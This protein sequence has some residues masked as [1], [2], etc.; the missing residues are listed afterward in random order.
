MR[1]CDEVRILLSAWTDGELADRDASAVAAHVA[2]C[3][4][5]RAHVDALRELDSRLAEASAANVTV[6]DRIAASVLTQF[7]VVDTVVDTVIDLHGKASDSSILEAAGQT[8]DGHTE[9][10]DDTP[11][12]PTRRPIGGP[13]RTTM[14]YL[15]AAA[16]GFFVAWLLFASRGE[17]AHERP[18]AGQPTVGVPPAAGNS[19]A[20]ANGESVT[21][22]PTLDLNLARLTVATGTVTLRQPG[23]SEWSATESNAPFQCS[24]G[25]EVRTGPGVRCELET[26]DRCTIRL[27]G[28]TKLTLRSPREVELHAGQIWCSSPDDVVLNVVARTAGATQRPGAATPLRFSC[29]SNG[30][31]LGEVDG[32]GGGRV[33]TA[34]GEVDVSLGGERH[35]LGPGEAAWL[36][37]GRLVIESHASDTLLAT[38]WMQPLLVLKGHDSPE[39]QD[40]IDRM[41]ANL[42]RSKLD[43]L[44]EHEIRSLGE[45]A[46]LPLLRFVQSAPSRAEPERRR[47]AM[48]IAAD[49]A[50][51]WLVG[52]LI[53]LLAD[54]DPTIRVAA[55]TAL[56]RLTGQ[57]H[58]REPRDWSAPVD[59]SD[60]ER[61]FWREW[62][63]DNRL[64]YP[65]S[66]APSGTSLHEAGAINPPSA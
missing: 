26:K 64:R 21:K 65:P 60:A 27:N 34:S 31:L 33:V 42:G 17:R 30:S 51:S 47:R 52:E 45:H 2:A 63:Q 22:A 7:G 14:Q 58:G 46:V 11:P 16:A 8:A 23:Q 50:P 28:D 9:Q 49:M 12:S 53:E 57:T 4:E 37:Q 40:R 29:P 44:Y 18:V 3:D 1:S 43:H 25:T 54:D 36:N 55:A 13:V 62:W 56:R 59:Q 24:I 32:A 10:T 48:A 15:A 20:S 41:F 5:C 19:A 6:A 39:L 66:R 38:S 61:E 35:R